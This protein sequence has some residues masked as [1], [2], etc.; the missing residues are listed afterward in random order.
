[1]LVWVGHSLRQAQ[2]K[3]PPKQSLNGAPDIGRT[4]VSDPHEIIPH[5]PNC[6]PTNCRR[7]VPAVG[8]PT[9]A[10][11]PEIPLVESGKL[12]SPLM[13]DGAE[14]VMWGIGRI[15]HPNYNRLKNRARWL[16][17]ADSL[18]PAQAEEMKSRPSCH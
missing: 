2:G 1:M 13:S 11:F 9:T 3:T 8:E 17:S 7:V 16:R 18:P 12:A 5:G 10:T 14:H 6:C 15:N 4:R